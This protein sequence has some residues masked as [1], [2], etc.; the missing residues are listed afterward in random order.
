[1]QRRRENSQEGNCKVKLERTVIE[2]K[3]KKESYERKGNETTS[4]ITKQ[5]TVWV[6]EDQGGDNC[7]E[8]KRMGYLWKGMGE[9]MGEQQENQK[10]KIKCQNKRN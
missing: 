5:R 3:R 1:M 2:K 8:K 4:T 10:V 9:E 6:W 7:R